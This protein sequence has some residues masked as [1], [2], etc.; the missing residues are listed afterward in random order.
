MKPRGKS[1]AFRSL[2]GRTIVEVRPQPFDNGIGGWAY[3]P[4]LIL[5]DGSRVIF[6]VQ[7]TQDP[8]TAGPGDY[9]VTLLHT[10]KPRKQA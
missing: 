8:E 3:A 2:V 5:D 7:E 10:R 4:V 6:S 9:G 1:A